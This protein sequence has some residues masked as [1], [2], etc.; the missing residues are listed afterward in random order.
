[1]ESRSDRWLVCAH[2]LITKQG[3]TRR[4]NSCYHFD[5]YWHDASPFGNALHRFK[6]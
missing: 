4:K 6:G 3:K 5:V 2:A 1:M